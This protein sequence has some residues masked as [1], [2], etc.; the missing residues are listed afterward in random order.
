MGQLGA[1]FT[2]RNRAKLVVPAQL[3]IGN[4]RLL[5]FSVARRPVVPRQVHAK[6]AKLG[7]T[8]NFNGAIDASRSPVVVTIPGRVAAKRGMRL[9]LAIEQPGLC[10]EANHQYPLGSNLCSS[11]S[12]VDATPDAANGVV[13]AEIRAPGGYRLQF[14]W[15]PE[16]VQATDVPE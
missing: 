8:L 16:D 13:S 12:I 9:V 2:L 3:P 14:G 6:F 1:T 4:S 15:V 10:D 7:P 5:A 11:W